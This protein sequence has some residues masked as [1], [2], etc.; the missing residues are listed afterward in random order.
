MSESITTIWLGV[1]VLL[2]LWCS[3]FKYRQT[4]ECN[5][6]EKPRNRWSSDHLFI[7]L[8]LGTGALFVFRIFIIHQSWRPLTSHLDG[9]TL[10][11]TLLCPTL[12]YLKKRGKARGLSLV[13]YPG[14]TFL[15]LWA[16]C[17]SRWT[18]RVF[19]PDTLMKGVH[20]FAVYLGTFLAFIAALCGATYLLVEDRLKRKQNLGQSRQ[21]A[22][23][24]TLERMIVICSAVGF[25]FISLG[26]VTGLVVITAISQAMP[27]GW[28]YRPKMVLSFSVWLV[29]ALLFNVRYTTFFR[30]SR[31]AWLSLLGLLLLVMTFGMVHTFSNQMGHSN[32]QKTSLEVPLEVS[33]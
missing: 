14:V 30:G 6:N 9:L 15:L 33:E 11:V 10:L 20:L 5:E 31:A 1:L 16:L 21:F 18:F 24:E 8:T 27:E 3:V 22:S 7:L 23:L 26:L 25:S 29:Y 28:W 13:G 32:P 19:T 17:S 2:G 12:I 4:F